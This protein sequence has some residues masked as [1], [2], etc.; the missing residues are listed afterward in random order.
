LWIT[1]YRATGTQMPGMATL[2]A[3]YLARIATALCIV[4]MNVCNMRGSKQLPYDGFD[5]LS[6]D[7]IGI[8]H[9][10]LGIVGTEGQQARAHYVRDFV[11]S[12]KGIFCAFSH[13]YGMACPI[14]SV[15]W[16]ADVIEKQKFL[17]DRSVSHFDAVWKARALVGHV[18]LDPM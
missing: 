4:R 3:V 13:E 6:I 2:G 8:Q 10:A 11:H 12:V 1:I 9:H 16:L 18:P 15:G 17:T 14:G 7:H 5:F